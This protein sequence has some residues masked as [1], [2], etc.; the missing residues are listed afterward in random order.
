MKFEFSFEKILNHR[1]G[2]EDIARRDWLVANGKLNQAMK[3]LDALF[4][5]IEDSRLRASKI[6]RGGG[7]LAPQLAMTDQFI[8]GQKIRVEKKRLEVR[9]LMG[10]A[11]RLHEILVEA[12]REKKVLEKLR[13]R[14]FADYKLLRKKMELK[15][16]DELTVTRARIKNDEFSS[17]HRGDDDGTGL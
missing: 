4:A 10:E 3:E 11:E 17:P 5:Q 7:P 15:A 8:N 13:E 1:R 2:L 12:A 6:E 14:R 16:A 9:E